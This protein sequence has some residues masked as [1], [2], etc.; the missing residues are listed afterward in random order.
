MAHA[1]GERRPTAQSPRNLRHHESRRL[2]HSEANGSVVVHDQFVD[3]DM[4]VEGSANWGTPIKVDDFERL[5]L[6]LLHT[7][8]TTTTSVSIAAQVRSIGVHDEDEDVLTWHDLYVDELGDGALV[9]KIWV[10]TTAVRCGRGL[11]R[12]DLRRSDALQ[13]VDRR[14]YA[15]GQPRSCCSPRG[16]WTPAEVGSPHG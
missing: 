12:S 8:G 15:G 1:E 2:A 3:A 5:A 10:L 11:G 16:T 14:S 4:V 13:G 9:R 7:A 6:H